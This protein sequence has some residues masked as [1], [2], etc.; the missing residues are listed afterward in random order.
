MDPRG[1]ICDAMDTF[2]YDDGYIAPEDIV[3]VAPED[4]ITVPAP[5]PPPLRARS[6]TPAE[7]DGRTVE[8]DTTEL[9]AL[10]SASLVPAA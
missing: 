9:A 1:L 10:V 7:E 8:I 4:R 3:E 6:A 5:P 2:E